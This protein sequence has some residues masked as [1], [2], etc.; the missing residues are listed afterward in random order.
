MGCVSADRPT[1][2]PI[3]FPSSSF[4]IALAFWLTLLE[5]VVIWV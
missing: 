1:I 3:F 4:G 2:V 5:L